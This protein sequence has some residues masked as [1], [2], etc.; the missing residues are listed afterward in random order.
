MLFANKF[1]QMAEIIPKLIVCVCV[2]WNTGK[3]KNSNLIW[4]EENG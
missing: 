4:D 2:C 1:I 3:K